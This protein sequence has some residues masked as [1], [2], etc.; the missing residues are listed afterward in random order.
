MFK[1]IIKELG[2]LLLL[3]IAITL[4]LA[5]LFYDYIPTNKAL[6]IK[7]EAY[8]IP[9]DIQKEIEQSST[10]EQNIVRTYYID[11]LDLNN[12]E[13]TKEYDKGKA[14]PFEDYTAEPPEDDNSNS[15]DTNNSNSSN[16]S[17]NSTNNDNTNNSSSGE[18][19]QNNT[20]NKTTQRNEVYMNTPGK[21]Y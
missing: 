15:S 8:D 12:Y 5:V 17:N 6:P 18:N 10:E 11:S 19:E 14:N 20:E 3:L 16:G 7:P 4:I 1:K 13:S 9:E 21:N 2:I